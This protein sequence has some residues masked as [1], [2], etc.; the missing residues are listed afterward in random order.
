MESTSLQALST[1]F[2]PTKVP[3]PSFSSFRKDVNAP[4]LFPLFLNVLASKR[5]GKCSSHPGRVRQNVSI[6]TGVLALVDG[7]RSEC[8]S[9]SKIDKNTAEG[10][11]CMKN[12]LPQ[13]G[14]EPTH[15]HVGWVI[16][17]I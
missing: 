6:L 15:V 3:N 16:S 13:V 11:A 2:S 17:S 1:G 10:Y 14:L 9:A 4:S 12:E 7:S 5:L 8:Y